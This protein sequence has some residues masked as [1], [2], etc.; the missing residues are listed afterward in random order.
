MSGTRMTFDR[1]ALRLSL[2]ALLAVAGCSSGSSSRTVIGPDG[3][4]GTPLKISYFRF[5]KEA[6]KGRLQAAFYV[7]LSWGWKNRFGPVAREP[8]E[9]VTNNVYR[10]V[11][12]ADPNMEKLIEALKEK[13]WDALPATDVSRIDLKRLSQL[14]R[15][16]SATT[17][18]V[19]PMRWLTVSDGTTTK[20]VSNEDA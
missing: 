7:M 10:N 15:E 8:F 6:A 11:E 20:T 4:E 17:E 9:R 2:L 14:D 19:G 13:G 1:L 12:I 5:Q 16:G 3:L 18:T